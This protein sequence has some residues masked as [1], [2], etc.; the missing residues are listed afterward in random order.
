MNPEQFN[1][2]PVL[3]IGHG[4][5]LNAVQPSPLA[6]RLTEV[7]SRLSPPKVVLVVSAH[8][9][10]DGVRVTAM[11]Q[12]RTI[13]D[14]S[15][16][17]DELFQVQYPA[18]GHPG[19]AAQFANEFSSR[20]VLL[21]STWGLDHGAWS[22]LVHL[23][24]K[25][26]TPV[27]QLSLD[28]TK[29]LHWHLEFARELGRLRSENVLIVA[30]GNIVHNLRHI[31]WN[32]RAEDA[33]GWATEF[34]DGVH[35]ALARRDFDA[36]VGPILDS[37]AARMSVPTLEHYLPL[38]YAAGASNEGDSLTEIHSGI[39]LAS[40]SMRSFAFERPKDETKPSLEPDGSRETRRTG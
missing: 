38:I 7:G 24:P 34:D 35:E 32:A 36:L 21:D 28:R 2:Q 30:S 13:H 5:P 26:Q 37:P 20:G 31:N 9:L 8:W 1:R 23:L 25:A 39:E 6:M 3:F 40:I 14:I 29:P 27:V 4:S 22:V 10:T 15:G 12:P 18:P 17:P 33:H 16:F 11:E 19:F